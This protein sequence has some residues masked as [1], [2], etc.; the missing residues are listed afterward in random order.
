MQLFLVGGGLAG[1]EGEGTGVRAAPLCNVWVSRN[2]PRSQVP[3]V[4]AP[5]RDMLEIPS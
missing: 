4:K 1:R 3:F 2:M 5:G